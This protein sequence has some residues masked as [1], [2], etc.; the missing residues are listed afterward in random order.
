MNATITHG[1]SINRSDHNGETGVL[2]RPA[3]E[4]PAA[5]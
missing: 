1:T 2:A 5:P 3:G 4:T